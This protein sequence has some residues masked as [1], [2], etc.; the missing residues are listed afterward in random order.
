MIY[1][2]LVI[3]QLRALKRLFTLLSFS[4]VLASN[5]ASASGLLLDRAEKAVLDCLDY[6]SQMNC[7]KA[8]GAVNNLELFYAEFGRKKAPQLCNAMA[9]L[10][11]EQLRLFAMGNEE[12]RKGILRTLSQLRK[13]GCATIR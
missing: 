3:E 7:E 1:T 4:L 13:E 2:V 5:P 8:I 9:M 11:H 12:M 6:S 10:V